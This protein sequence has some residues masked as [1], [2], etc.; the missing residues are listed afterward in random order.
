M[1][2][3]ADSFL[4]LC[5]VQYP[6]LFC[7]PLNVFT[8][9]AVAK[10][11]IAVIWID[12][13][14][15]LLLLS[16]LYSQ[17][18]CVLMNKKKKG[19]IGSCIC[20]AEMCFVSELN[21]RKEMG[22]IKDFFGPINSSAEQFPPFT[23]SLSPRWRW[24]WCRLKSQSSCT[25][26]YTVVVHGPELEC[27]VRSSKKGKV[28]KKAREEGGDCMLERSVKTLSLTKCCYLQ[29]LTPKMLLVYSTTFCILY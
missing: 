18:F 2:D 7:S 24:R 3:L 13:P 8:T 5:G 23:Y 9:A 10:H 1:S 17:P 11:S 20:A 21:C 16:F 26:R 12:L 28:S 19:D 27:Q 29:I 25:V 14:R 15:T 6:L 4:S 22:G